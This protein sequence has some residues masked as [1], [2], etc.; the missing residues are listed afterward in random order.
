MG[1]QDGYMIEVS[2][3]AKFQAS[4]KP[5]VT[6]SSKHANAEMTNAAIVVFFSNFR[7]WF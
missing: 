1:K 4:K 2:P 7:Q 3:K 6:V 5:A